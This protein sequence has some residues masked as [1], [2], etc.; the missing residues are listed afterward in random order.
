MNIEQIKEILSDGTMGYFATLNGQQLELR[1]WQY[2][3]SEENKFYF[4]TTN[5]KDV[6]KQMQANPQAAFSCT[7][8]EHNVRISGKA[9][10][11]T[12][13][14]EKEKTFAKV[15]PYVQEMYKSASNPVVEIFYIGSGEVKV[16]K[17]FEPIEVVKF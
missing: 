13:A 2:Q 10:F 17:G 16:N 3:F 8:N 12:D 9:T 14:A 15:S 6:Y 4:M 11:V 1:G 7:S 5:T